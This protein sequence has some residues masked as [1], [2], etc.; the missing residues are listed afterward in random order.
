MD[1]G[2]PPLRRPGAGPA[3]AVDAR[4]RVWAAGADATCAGAESVR[5][6]F[7]GTP[8]APPSPT[9]SRSPRVPLRVLSPTPTATQPGVS[10]LEE[11]GRGRPE[12]LT[13]VSRPRPRPPLTAVLGG[14]AGSRRVG[15]LG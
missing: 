12:G 11:E 3:G 10:R 4:A 9:L 5:A 7:R 13:K 8:P 14:P 2:G 6:A 15:D 1:A